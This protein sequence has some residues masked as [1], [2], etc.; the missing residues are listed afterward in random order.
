[1]ANDGPIGRANVELGATT[2]KLATDLNTAKDMTVKAVTDTEKAVAQ[3]A[4]PAAVV[5]TEATVKQA[6]AQ[7]RQG[8]AAEKATEKNA[9]F[10]DGLKNLTNPARLA[11]GAINGIIGSFYSVIGLVGGVVGAFAAIGAALNAKARAAAA[12]NREIDKLGNSLVK[13]Q[14]TPLPGT[15]DP[16]AEATALKEAFQDR[17]TAENTLYQMKIDAADKAGKKITGSNLEEERKARMV[18][19][20]VE[21]AD[22]LA[23]LRK[24][25][26][27]MVNK[28]K[29]DEY[30]LQEEKKKIEEQ[31]RKDAIAML[32]KDQE[33]TM[34]YYAKQIREMMRAQREQ[35]AELRNDINGLFNTSGLEV[36]I[37]R[38]GQLIETLIQKVGDNR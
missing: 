14:N 10:T 18:A 33:E 20:Q 13:L 11:V 28:V 34:D 29:A 8:K 19:L 21:M 1:M 24:Y 27:A 23:S 37:N 7:E 3:Q 22:R 35:F 36:G 26:D 6:E 12:A 16:D 5:V 32:V 38:V 25:Q 9:T 15:F 30:I 4:T 31:A 2:T 17:M